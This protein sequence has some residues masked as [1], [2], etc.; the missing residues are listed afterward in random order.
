M[1]HF[2][3]PWEYQK[4][5]RFC[6]VFKGYRNLILVLNVVNRRTS[7]RSKFVLTLN[8]NEE[9]A[10]EILRYYIFHRFLDD[11]RGNRNPTKWPNTLKQ[12]VGKLP[13][14]CLSVFGHFINLVLKGLNSLNNRSEICGWSLFFSNCFARF[15]AISTISKTWKAMHVEV[16]LLVKFQADA[17]NVTKSN[18]RHGCFSA[19]LNPLV[20]GVH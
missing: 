7:K 8:L 16:L 4:T 5:L 9:R 3:I 15:G 13:T 17:C 11:F 18:N 14:N 12:F 6:V 10:Y 2:Y 19:N 20:P 1:L